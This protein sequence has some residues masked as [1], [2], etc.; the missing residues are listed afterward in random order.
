MNGGVLILGA[1]GHGKYIADILLAQGSRILGFLDDNPSL[2]GQQQLGFPILGPISA[3]LDFDSDGLILGI[4]SNSSRREIA[5]RLGDATQGQWVNAIHPR[6]VVAPSVQIGIGIVVGAGAIISPDVVIGDHTIISTAA[7][8]GHDSVIGRFVHVGPGAHLAGGVQVLDETFL[9]VGTSVI[10]GRRI[11]SKTVVGAGAVVV[12]DI[13]D[14]VV[15][16][17]VPARW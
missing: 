6:S 3:Y 9:G 4:G 5:E 15:A 12:G 14:K 8:V 13:P 7:T 16:K 17:G 10:P 1:S 2:Y 11:G